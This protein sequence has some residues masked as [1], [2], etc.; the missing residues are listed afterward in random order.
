M[1]L[2]SRYDGWGAVVSESIGVG[3]PVIVSTACGSS[4]LV[5]SRLQ[6]N[7]FHS[8]DALALRS[9]LT[10]RIAAGRVGHDQRRR[11]RDWA[12]NHSSAQVLATHLVDTLTRAETGVPWQRD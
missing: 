4:S 12:T 8:G 6:G 10:V 11:L 1:V 5:R 7:T 3:T 2:P 9:H